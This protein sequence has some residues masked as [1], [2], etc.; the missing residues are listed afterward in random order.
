MIRI[1][2]AAALASTVWVGTATASVD[3]FA[4]ETFAPVPV[5]STQVAAATVD[6]LIDDLKARRDDGTLNERDFQT[7]RNFEQSASAASLD[8]LIDELK[9]RRDDGTLTDAD[10]REI[11]QFEQAA[12]SVEELIDDLKARRD[13]GTLNERD[14]QTIRNFEQS[15]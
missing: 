11:R 15:A 10:F 7:I 3:P 5:Q 4:D 8:E 1:I 12:A 9:A 14:F 6:Q 13:D 2:T